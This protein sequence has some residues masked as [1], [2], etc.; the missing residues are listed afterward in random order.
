MG[1]MDECRYLDAVEGVVGRR[2]TQARHPRIPPKTR[3]F[4]T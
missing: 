1:W 3:S 2:L 4:Q